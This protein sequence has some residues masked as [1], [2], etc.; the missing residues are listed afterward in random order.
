[1]NT[2]RLLFCMCW[3]LTFNTLSANP[4]KW[5]N[6]LKQFSGKLPT[7]CLSVFDRGVGLA[8]KGL[9]HQNNINEQC[10]I[11]FI[12]HLELMKNINLVFFYYD[13]KK[14]FLWWLPWLCRICRIRRNKKAFKI[15]KFNM[16]D[17][18]LKD[19]QS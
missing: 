3:K 4:T 18:F 9:R 13:F 5:S 17:K 7:N 19:L 11:V 16:P 1:M 2:S 6:T 8:L 14:I 15:A 10:S 12:V